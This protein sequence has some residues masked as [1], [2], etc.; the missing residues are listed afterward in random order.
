MKTHYAPKYFILLFILGIIWGSSFI[1]MKIGL[2]TM[3][4]LELAAWRNA[5]ALL[6]SLP[7]LLPACKNISFKDWGYVL[8]AALFGS[9]IP[10]ILYALASTKIDSSMNGVL[11]ALTPLFTLLF[12]V[13]LFK[14]NS[15]QNKWLGVIIGF[16]GATLLI[17][18][19]NGTHRESDINY[20][21]LPVLAAACYGISG[22]TVK[23]YLTKYNTFQVTAML[24]LFLGIPAFFFLFTSHS[25]DRLSFA[26]FEW[27]FW[28][29]SIDEAHQ[30]VASYTAIFILGAIGT[31]VANFGFY[32]LI[33]RTSVL[34]GAMTT[35]II[36][37][38]ALFWGFVAGEKI[39]W[40]HLVSIAL[41]CLGIWEVSR[42]KK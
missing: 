36:P 41:I 15:L 20:L 19:G 26:Y 28:E 6:T 40:V 34:F 38:V 12:G 37:M 31:A 29:L 5:S 23:T 27:R 39:S 21:I 25:F 30:K 4:P 3:A 22:N 9:G 10:A 33:K 14:N 13:Y 18:S 11:N 8:I 16:A 17:L 7:F 35:Y 1:L 42:T 24:Y 2:R 32:F